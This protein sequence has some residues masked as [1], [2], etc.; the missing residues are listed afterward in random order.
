MVVNS[1]FPVLC[2]PMGLSPRRKSRTNVSKRFI[3]SKVHSDSERVRRPNPLILEASNMIRWW[4]PHCVIS[5]NCIYNI[6]NPSHQEE[7]TLVECFEQ[8]VY[9]DKKNSLLLLPRF[10]T[11]LIYPLPSFLFFLFIGQCPYPHVCA[12]VVSKGHTQWF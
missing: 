8:Y 12:S 4:A 11:H 5:R 10:F 7:G 2:S 3:I 1:H 9:A 6:S